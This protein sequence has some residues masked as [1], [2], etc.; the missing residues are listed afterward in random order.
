MLSKDDLLSIA[1]NW[2]NIEDKQEVVNATIDEEIEAIENNILKLKSNEVNDDPEPEV[3]VL[4]VTIDDTDKLTKAQAEDIVS[5]LKLNCKHLGV[6]EDAFNHLDQFI[7]LVRNAKA[8][9]SVTQ[10]SLHSFFSK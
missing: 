9:K 2:V 3:D 7:R 10:G 8:K 5:Q 4:A 6:D 1:N